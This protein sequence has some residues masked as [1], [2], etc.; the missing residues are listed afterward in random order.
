VQSLSGSGA[1][2][3]AQI[4]VVQDGELKVSIPENAAVDLAG[5]GSVGSEELSRLVDTISPHIISVTATNPNGYYKAGAVLTVQVQLSEVVTL[6]GT[7]KLFLQTGRAGAYATYK[8]G[9]NSQLLIFE[10]TVTDGDNSQDLDYTSVEALVLE[11]STIT[12]LALHALD[13]SLPALGSTQSLAALKD[14]IIDTLP[15]TVPVILSPQTGQTLA[16]RSVT[17]SGTT[18]ANSSLD[19]VTADDTTLCSTTTDDAGSWSCDASGLKDGSYAVRARAEDLAGNLSTST[20][21]E[22]TVNTTLPSPPLF[23]EPVHGVTTDT[24]PRFAG[25]ATVAMLV[26]VQLDGN[27][28]C[29][30]T[31]DSTGSW[32]CTSTVSLQA[33]RYAITGITEDP[34][35]SARSLPTSLALTVGSHFRG[36]VRKANRSQEPLAEVSISDGNTT[37]QTDLNGTYSLV[38]VDPTSPSITA[39]KKGWRISRASTPEVGAASTDPGV[40]WYAV[41]ALEPETYTVWNGALLPFQPALRIL[42]R[43]ANPQPVS[44]TLYQA[45]GTECT[46]RFNTTAEPL[47]YITIPLESATC[48]N[49]ES[50][51]L[52]KIS[53]PSNEYDGELTMQRGKTADSHL[54]SVFSLPLSNSLTGTSYVL[55]DNAYHIERGGEQV[56]VM[57]NELIISNLASSEKRFT[58]RRYRS[59]TSLTKSEVMVIPARG[60]ARV[61]F[62][63]Q[64]EEAQENGIQEIEPDDR[65]AP[66]TAVL[67]RSGEQQLRPPHKTGKFLLMDHARA[68]GSKNHFARVRYLPKR[69]AV[70]Y[71]EIANVSS[72]GV[73]VQVARVN[74]RGKT[75]PSISIYLKPKET[76]KLRLSRLL[77][78]YQEGMAHISSDIPDSI[79]VNS[80]M[81]HYRGDSKLLSIKTL[82]IRET[83][84]DT[85]YGIYQRIGRTKTLLKLTN[86]DGQEVQGSVMCYRNSQLQDAVQYSLKPS[87][88]TELLLEKCFNGASGGVVEVNSSRPGTVVADTLL[89]RKSEDINLP[90]RLR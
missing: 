35:D 54:T 58:V 32:S 87:G 6:S 23:T 57:R 49:A 34:D 13:T 18:E 69:F 40:V 42:N 73:N 88:Q 29:T 66:Y 72:Q 24:K 63:L 61:E 28:L 27:D 68:G 5:N 7:P 62:P 64:A 17:I 65:A 19:I 15:P 3:S 84:G 67:A 20:S 55:V 1:S 82:S 36:V 50:Y 10:Y 38:T 86:V 37:T 59:N 75:R 41:P 78:R 9:D 71:A 83:F 70:Q 81:K 45:N 80:V 52:V 33:G 44:V 90:G 74:R 30:A 89:F 12:D 4:L 85:L 25:T 8:D 11:Q 47:N 79:I 56:Y 76:R 39:T 60:S 26:H 2:Y 43:S 77:E 46:E 22:F 51:G 14:I 21:T 48:F 16:S 53:Y 31:V